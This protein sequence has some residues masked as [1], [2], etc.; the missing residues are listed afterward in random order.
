MKKETGK[1][2][3]CRF[4]DDWLSGVEIIWEGSWE[5]L[6]FFLCWWKGCQIKSSGITIQW[7]R[8]KKKI[9]NEREEKVRW[10]RRIQCKKD[11]SK[12]SRCVVWFF[13]F[14]S[15]HFLLL[16]SNF[17]HIEFSWWMKERMWPWMMFEFAVS[18][19]FVGFS[20]RLN[21]SKKKTSYYNAKKLSL[22][23]TQ[24]MRIRSEIYPF[25]SIIIYIEL[26]PLIFLT[27]SIH[28]KY[29]SI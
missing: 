19:L 16:F 20:H 14:V 17:L 21:M 28:L 5:F 11:L 9:W 12:F 10:Q 2:H 22:N 18:G 8:A 15:E 24:K 1:F 7:S 6:W 25:L 27:S 26:L 3:V 23:I 13:L 4:F 29:T